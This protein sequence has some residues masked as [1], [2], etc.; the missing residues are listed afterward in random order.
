MICGPDGTV[1]K[2]LR[3]DYQIA[4]TLNKQPGFTELF[5]DDFAER[6]LAMLDEIRGK[7]ASF[8]WEFPLKGFDNHR[9]FRFAGIYS[10]E[11]IILVAGESTEEVN[12]F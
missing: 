4:N 10:A 8:N 2:F 9:S 3:D 11:T 12:Q 1:L 7:S 6:A 5:P